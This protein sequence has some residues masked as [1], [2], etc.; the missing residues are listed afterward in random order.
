ETTRTPG[1][2]RA[3]SLVRL[4]VMPS[5]MW[6][7]FASPLRL[8]N[9]RA[10]IDGAAALNRSA[11]TISLAGAGDGLASVVGRGVDVSQDARAMSSEP[12]AAAEA[13]KGK[14]CAD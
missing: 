9:G 8:T 10:R 4:S 13:T 2:A 1:N 5:A 11:D 12:S 6:S 3:R 14:C 7:C